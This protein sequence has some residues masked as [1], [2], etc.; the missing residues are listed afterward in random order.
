ME[1]PT[2]LDLDKLT[3][4]ARYVNGTRELGLTFNPT[5]TQLHCSADASFAINAGAKSQT[6]VVVQLGGGLLMASSKRQ[7]L[8]T[9]STAESE[10]VAL[11]S[12]VQ[13]VVWLRGLL[14]EIGFKQ[15]N[16][17][18]C[19][20]DNKSTIVLATRGAGGGGKS[21]SINVRYFWMKEKVEDGSI[22]IAYTPTDDV[23]ADGMT[24]A[25]PRDKFLKWRRKILG[26]GHAEE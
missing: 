10:L 11:S 26:M 2:Q 8:V 23:V 17:T 24:K 25:L 13:D 4:V 5:T 22:E 14:E 3:H 21:R 16:P 19:E 15:K 12:A 7:K 6:G 18:K 9:L 20:Q 1:K